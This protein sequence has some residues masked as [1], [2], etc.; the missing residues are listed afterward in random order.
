M[1]YVSINGESFGPASKDELENWHKAG[2]FNPHDFV[3]DESAEQWIT[4]AQFASISDIFNQPAPP[5]SG[6]GDI[7]ELDASAAIKESEPAPP[8]ETKCP[9]HE[10]TAADFVCPVCG[11]A[12]CHDCVGV[13]DGLELCFDCMNKERAQ[14]GNPW[15]KRLTAAGAVFGIV[16]VVILTFLIFGDQPPAQSETPPKIPIDYGPVPANVQNIEKPAI[17]EQTVPEFVVIDETDTTADEADTPA[18]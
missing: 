2:S 1:Y 6:L 5:A 17:D 11:K 12:Y 16:L 9:Y 15:R 7:D 18:P 4:A 3:W 8:G 10:D 14:Q 13:L